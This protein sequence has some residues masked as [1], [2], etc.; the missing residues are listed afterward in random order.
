MKKEIKIAYIGGGSKLWARVFMSDLAV[1]EG[2][3]GEIALYDIDVPAAER[4]ARIG[5]YINKDKRTKSKFRYTVCLDISDALANADFVVLSILPAT[6]K[7]MCADVHL[8]EKYG[9]YQS[10]GDTAG[11]GGVLRSMRTVPMY[12]G[13]ARAIRDICPEA[14]VINFT[15]PMSICVKTL[16]D[17]FPQIKAFGCCHE[18]FHAQEFLTCVLKETR[19]IS[20]GRED[21]F[22]D[23][24]GVNHFTW[25]TE[26]KYGNTDL[27][28]LIPEFEEK[29]Y[30]EGYYEKGGDLRFA[31]RT[32]PFAY[33]NK[34]KMDLFNKYG[35][36]AAAGDRHLAEFMP[37]TWYL[38]DEKTVRDWKFCLTTVDY[39]EKM[40]EEKVA[41][42]E[43][44]AQGKKPFPVEKSDEVAVRMMQ[45]IMG[46]GTYVTNVNMP[47]RGQMPRMP[48]GSI[49]E[50]N[51][52]FSHD[53][54]MPIVSRPLPIAAE[55]LVHRACVNIDTLY[56]G[57][58]ERDLNKIFLSF[59][60]QALCSS[61]TPKDALSLFK[62]M[63]YATRGYL[64]EYFDLDGFFNK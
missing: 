42:S 22:T 37:N 6:L 19:G 39:R 25:I 4:N 54:V 38:K 16:Y 8:P 36:L 28:S 62:E 64:D 57:I 49:V 15:N 45:A 7:E 44:M 58:K 35:A 20:V 31:F 60:N 18:V 47:N 26:A 2:L 12:E 29:Y 23:A 17:V 33:G 10:V 43:E 11:P 3:S 27:L 13:F 61:L 24:S 5:A 34:V 40:Q 32:D 9:I 53:M 50:T 59:V 21:I 56:E 41:E 14:W 52:T 51:C 1:A 30:E 63:C 46:F 55:N 48:L